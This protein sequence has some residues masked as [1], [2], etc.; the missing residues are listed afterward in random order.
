VTSG[1]PVC[2]IWVEVNKVGMALIVGLNP[3]AL[4]QEAGIEADNHAMST[5]LEYRDLIEFK[6]LLHER[7]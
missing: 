3:V 2:E 7:G 4:A 1:E 6:E 5:A